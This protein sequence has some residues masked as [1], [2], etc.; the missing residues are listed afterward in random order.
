M[1]LRETGT[2]AIIVIRCVAA[3][4]LIFSFPRFFRFSA[5]EDR[6]ATGPSGCKEEE[7]QSCVSLSDASHTHTH[8]HT[9]LNNGHVP[10]PVSVGCLRCTYSTS[11]CSML[12]QDCCFRSIGCTSSYRHARFPEQEL[13]RTSCSGLNVSSSFLTFIVFPPRRSDTFRHRLRY[14]TMCSYSYLALVFI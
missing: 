9:H 12:Q 2:A 8:T 14:D 7:V 11:L 5:A 13:S 4:D 3:S 1:R 6:R 10:T